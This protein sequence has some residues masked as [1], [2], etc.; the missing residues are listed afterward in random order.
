[1]YAHKI[2]TLWWN[3]VREPQTWGFAKN[4]VTPFSLHTDDHETLFTWHIVPLPLYLQYEDKLSAQPE[5][6]VD[7]FTK[8]E[9][10]KMLKDPNVRLVISCKHTVLFFDTQYMVLYWNPLAF[11][12]WEKEWYANPVIF[13]QFMGMPAMLPKHGV[14]I[15]TTHLPTRLATMSWPLTT[16]GLATR[17]AH[18]QKMD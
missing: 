11:L 5:G 9:N 3:D 15:P 4:Q 18:L 2:H 6:F 16:A 10:F 14:P 12:R 17:Q 13:A 1:M 8:T 7:D